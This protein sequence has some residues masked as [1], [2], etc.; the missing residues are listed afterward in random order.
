MEAG[1]EVWQ[2][3]P[4]TLSVTIW[5][6]CGAKCVRKKGAE[7]ITS[8]LLPGFCVAASELFR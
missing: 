2:V 5:R 4:V 6:T 8:P 7:T 3:Y 1:V